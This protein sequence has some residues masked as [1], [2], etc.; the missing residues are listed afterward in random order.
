M[1]PGNQSARSN[2]SA[3]NGWGPGALPA[4]GTKADG[5]HFRGTTQQLV[6]QCP[7]GLWPHITMQIQQLQ[8]APARSERLNTRTDKPV[9][10][11]VCRP[12]LSHPHTEDRNQVLNSMRT[13][14]L[15]KCT[16]QFNFEDHGNE[17]LK[18]A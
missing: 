4:W 17:Q 1:L 7:R 14:F 8:L 3:R 13:L 10:A 5:F 12:L 18:Q 2:S 6:T 9:W 11:V 16:C 15:H